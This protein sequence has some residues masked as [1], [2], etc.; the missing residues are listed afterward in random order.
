[1]K[2]KQVDDFSLMG[3]QALDL[4]IEVGQSPWEIRSRGV[5]V[6]CDGLLDTTLLPPGAVDLPGQVQ[7]Q[8]A[9][10]LGRQA[11]EVLDCGRLD[12]LQGVKK[13][14]CDFVGDIGRINQARGPPEAG[15]TP[16]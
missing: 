14:E 10:S 12:F 16:T 13:P 15:E 8:P 9:D 1:M 5:V 4:L 11:E 3:G 6:A 7:E 2:I